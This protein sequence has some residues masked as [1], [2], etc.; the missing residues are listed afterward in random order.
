MPPLL[1]VV[2]NSLA[3]VMKEASLDG[4][5]G[6]NNDISNPIANFADI[7][8]ESVIKLLRILDES[9]RKGFKKKTLCAGNG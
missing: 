7:F 1:G 9:E 4:L 6:F 8:I 5:D 2:V 3:S